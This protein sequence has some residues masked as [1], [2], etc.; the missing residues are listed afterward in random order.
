MVSLMKPVV[1]EEDKDKHHLV[2][3]KKTDI[4]DVIKQSTDNHIRA[5]I[6]GSSLV[7]TTV[8]FAA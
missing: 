7:A 5:E 8:D 2:Y 4:G 1:F 6:H 3:Y